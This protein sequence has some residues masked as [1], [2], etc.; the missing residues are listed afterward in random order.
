MSKNIAAL[1]MC[2][3]QL[4]VRDKPLGAPASVKLVYCHYSDK[5]VSLFCLNNGICT[6]EKTVVILKQGPGGRLN[7][8]ML[9]YQSRDSHVKDKTV[10]PS[11]LSLTWECHTWERWSLYWNRS[12][13]L[14]IPYTDMICMY[15]TWISNHIHSILLD[16]IT[17]PCLNPLHAKLFRGNLKHIFTFFVIPPHWYDTGGWNP[18]SNKTRTYPFY[19]VN[20]MAAGVLATQGART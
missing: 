3:N 16:V 12:G 13:S 18:S 6:P 20:I 17:Y 8:K 1:E 19:K 14:G 9:S 11:V 15:M 7:I 2:D 10:S 4:L 5:T